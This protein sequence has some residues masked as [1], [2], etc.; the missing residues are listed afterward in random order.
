MEEMEKTVSMPKLG[1]KAPDFEALTTFGTLK[2]S[3]FKGKLGDHVLAPGGLHASVH[4]RV[5]GL[6]QDPA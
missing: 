2:L 5:H 1:E 6:R 4:D 3:D